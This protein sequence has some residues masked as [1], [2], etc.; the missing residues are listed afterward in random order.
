MARKSSIGAAFGLIYLYTAEL[1]PAIMRG[2]SLIFS[3]FL[4]VFH[5]CVTSSCLALED[6][7]AVSTAVAGARRCGQVSSR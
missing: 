4:V 3:C 6:K 7:D 1:R 2:G 5:L